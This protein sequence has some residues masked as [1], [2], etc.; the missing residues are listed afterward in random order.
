MNTETKVALIEKSPALIGFLVLVSFLFIYSGNIDM[1][2]DRI[3][4]FE[5]AGI[6][7]EFSK[8]QVP[9]AFS[10]E[11]ANFNPG[12][13]LRSRIGYLSAPLKRSTMLVLHD[14]PSVANWLANVFRGM[15]M[16]VDVGICS[17]GAA[18][19]L[20]HHYDVILSDM[21]W[22]NCS[23]GAK[24]AVDFLD[25]VDPSG[26]RVV[27]YISNLMGNRKHIPFYA[28][29]LTNSFEGML[30]GVLDVISRSERLTN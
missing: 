28:H 19:L 2:V 9:A 7:L 24:D 25:Q 22:S 26:A 17:D 5:I 11:V 20:N 13:A 10:D 12:K 29:E 18:P 16:T 30:N 8:K 6:S 21:N 4:R 27:F 15:G 23:I 14:E 1:Y 3:T